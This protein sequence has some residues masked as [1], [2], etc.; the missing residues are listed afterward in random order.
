MGEYPNSVDEHD[1]Y[2]EKRSGRRGESNTQ[3]F[4]KRGNVYFLTDK[5]DDKE[6]P[7]LL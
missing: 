7:R 3:Y 2:H 1:W 6:G 5:V 4:E